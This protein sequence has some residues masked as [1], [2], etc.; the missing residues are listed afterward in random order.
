MK[1]TIIQITT[2]CGLVLLA[3]GGYRYMTYNKPIQDIVAKS[4]TSYDQASKVYSTVKLS[5]K[6]QNTPN[7][8]FQQ[9]A[10]RRLPINLYCIFSTKQ[11]VRIVKRCS[12]SNKNSSKSYQLKL[13]ATS[14]T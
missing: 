12:L 6:D 14:I 13:K 2:V 4:N 8:D 7:K 3:Y 9:I 5:G 11:V 10:Q 1:K